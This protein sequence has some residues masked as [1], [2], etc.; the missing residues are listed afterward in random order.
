MRAE[1]PV[2]LAILKWKEIEDMLV[3]GGCNE[4]NLR[5]AGL[6]YQKGFIAGFQAGYE[7]KE[8]EECEE[9]QELEPCVGFTAPETEEEED[10]E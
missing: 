3:E 10:D 4:V 1:N 2:D 7:H 9:T 5:K 6:Y 8:R